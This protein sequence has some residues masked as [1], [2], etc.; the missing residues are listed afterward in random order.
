[1]AYI[2]DLHIHS[3]YSRATSKEMELEPLA[4]WAKIKGISLLGTGDFT[5]PEWLAE[6]EGSLKE[7]GK[8]VYGY[9]GMEF[10]LT[11]EVSN[12]YFKAGRTRKVHIILAAPG[13]KSAREINKALAQYGDL[14]SDGRPVISLGCDRMVKLLSSID[15]GI[16]FIP[17][18]A[19]TP[20]FGFLG[21]NSGF[22]TPEECFEEQLP[23]IYSIETGLSSDPAMNWRYSK[24]DRFCL[25]S[26]SD[27]HSPSKIG[28]E[29][30]VF[31]ERIDYF[32]LCRILKTKD[33]SRFLH[34]IEFFPEEGK[35]HWD[36]HR[37][38]KARLSP[39]E[40]IRNNKICPVC[41]K[42]VTV[43]VMHRLEGLS[44][45]PEGFILNSS[46]SFKTMVPLAEIIADALGL[47][48]DS[49]KVERQYH[50]LIKNFGSEF[51]ILLEMGEAELIKGLPGPIAK[52]IINVR[53]GNVEILPGY[54]GEYGE[55]KVLREED[56]KAEKQLSLF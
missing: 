35:Y 19:W 20:H 53:R 52:G 32:E 29:A 33:K 4:R 45:R 3:K 44:D 11:A 18:H 51:H 22:D 21:S 12:I 15:P 34:T 13:F 41:G 24:L 31:K 28:R 38:C 27:A 48:A 43:G 23:R 54:D 5:H 17:A 10:I 40:T 42:K 55:V 37:N 56:K 39:K 14:A 26:N 36:G 2:A 1:M 50:E 30:N 9:G 6:L 16:L 49:V 46:P 25:T 47:G 7:S 8:G